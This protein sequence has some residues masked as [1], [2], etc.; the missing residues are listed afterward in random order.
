MHSGYELESSDGNC[1]MTSPRLQPGDWRD[2]CNWWRNCH[3]YQE[4]KVI[5]VPQYATLTLKGSNINSPIPIPDSYRVSGKP[6]VMM[7]VGKTRSN[8]LS[9]P[10]RNRSMDRNRKASLLSTFCEKLII[11]ARLIKITRNPN[12]FVV[13][14]INTDKSLSQLLTWKN[15]TLQISG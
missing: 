8:Y 3:R 2:K 5:H 15:F 14:V 11:R 6:G 10:W 9:S 7:F 1:I 12:Q 13:R 4:V